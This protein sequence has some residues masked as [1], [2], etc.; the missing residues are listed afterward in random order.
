MTVA[1]E[2]KGGGTL[3][4]RR[5]ILVLAVA[6]LMAAM[7]VVMAAPAFASAVQCQG[8][9][10][11]FGSNISRLAADGATGSF[12]PPGPKDFGTSF[13]PGKHK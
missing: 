1:T 11:A 12:N 4:L 7:M 3:L 9:G 13:P 10:C 2:E 8:N 6:A 5:M